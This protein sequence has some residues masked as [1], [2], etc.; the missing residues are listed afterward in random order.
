MQN[1]VIYCKGKRVF[2]KLHVESTV[3][4]KRKRDNSGWAAQKNEIALTIAGE[5]P[6][7]RALHDYS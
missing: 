3:R 7:M 4:S 5:T 1:R 6:C 2:S